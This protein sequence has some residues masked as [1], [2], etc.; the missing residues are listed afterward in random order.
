MKAR[1]ALFSTPMVQALLDDRKNNT[2]RLKGLDGFNKSP[3]LFRYDGTCTDNKNYHYMESLSD[4]QPTEQYFD[5][6]CP[7]GR[8]GD[9][10]YVRETCMFQKNFNDLKTS[11]IP[12]DTLVGYKA[13][14]GANVY[15]KARPS[16]F[17][18]RWASRL[19]LK[20]TDIRVERLQDISEEDSVQEGYPPSM[21]MD[22]IHPRMWF[23]DLWQSINGKESW[24]TNPWVWV[25][26]F[27]VHKMNVDE[28]LKQNEV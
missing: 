12:K 2:R 8:V 25:I 16:I 10:L 17:M 13:G 1:P 26:E 18:P 27:K 21:G 14:Y 3:N 4:G 28:Y 20:I 7:F 23:E 9:L 19:T 11:E 22:C 6:K 5:V 15:G 24:D